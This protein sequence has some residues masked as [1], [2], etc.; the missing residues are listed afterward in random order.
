M[1][2]LLLVGDGEL[3]N[4]IEKK[5]KN[6]GLSDSVIF[7]GVRS[8]AHDLLQAMDVFVFP[9]IYEGL[10][11]VTIEAQAAGLPCIVSDVIPKEADVTD[12]IKKISLKEPLDVWVENIIK[13]SNGYKRRNT[14][15]E[16]KNAGY[17]IYDMVKQIEGFYLSCRGGS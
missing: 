1:T 5:V 10:G 16:I 7:S 8:D 15:K 6:L 17:D 14:Y 4:T 11:I 12:L 9:S 3:H 13:F 2:V